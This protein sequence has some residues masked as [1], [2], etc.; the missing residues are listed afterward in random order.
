MS[1]SSA[2]RSATRRLI[3]TLAANLAA[4]T[5]GAAIFRVPDAA[6]HMAAL[7]M[8]EAIERAG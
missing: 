4:L 7:K 6:E 3:V 1:A 2:I 5:R 8:F